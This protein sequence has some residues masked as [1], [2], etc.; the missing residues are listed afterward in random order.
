MNLS[1]SWFSSFI[2]ESSS[3]FPKS[4]SSTIRYHFKIGL[5]VALITLDVSDLFIL[6]RYLIMMQTSWE[7]GETALKLVTKST[8]F[9]KP[10]RAWI[11]KVWPGDWQ[12][13][14]SLDTH[15]CYYCCSVSK[16]CLT[17]WW[18]LGLQPIRLLC[19]WDFSGKN[20]GVCW[21]FLLQGIF[22]T[23]GLNPCLLH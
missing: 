2:W 10:F 16:S 8:D 21:H 3:Q 17:L 4:P 5:S 18:P 7:T 13:Q 22:P 23:Q 14:H 11:L 19:P 1:V 6:I 20:T 9:L 15:C 12:H